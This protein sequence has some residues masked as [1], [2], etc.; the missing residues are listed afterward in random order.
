MVS[1]LTA[2]GRFLWASPSTQ[3]VLGYSPEELTG[4]SA[5]EMIHPA[6]RP[7]AEGLLA[8]T[9]ATPN[10]VGTLSYRVLHRDGSWR[11]LEATGKN[12]LDDPR[13]EGMVLNARDVTD[14]VLAARQ[15]EAARQAAE[16]AN[17]A[18]TA[19]LSRISHELR[20]PLNAI[21]GFAQLLEQD[22]VSEDDRESTSQILRAGHHLMRLIDD[23]LQ[24]SRIE[25]GELQISMEPVR[26]GEV[27]SQALELVRPA[28]AAANVQIHAPAGA[29][30]CIS[31]DVQR[32]RQVLLNLFTNAI[33]Y[34][35]RG[36]HVFIRI[37][38]RPLSRVRVRIADTGRG[39]PRR[40]KPSLFTPFD[41]LGVEST[42]IEGTGLGLA[43]SRRLVEQMNGSIGARS[44]ETRG[45]IFW[46]DLDGAERLPEQPA[47]SGSQHPANHQE[48]PPLSGAILFVDD[49]PSGTRLM[50]RITSSWPDVRLFTATCAGDAI[51]IAAISPPDLLIL[52]LH[53]PDMSGEQLLTRLRSLPHLSRIPVLIVTADVTAIRSTALQRLLPDGFILKPYQLEEMRRSIRSALANSG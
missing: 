3:R 1:V 43:L 30:L 6:D 28:A 32:L 51:Q 2:D 37:S 48:G 31:A 46:V 10:A 8:R 11:E 29:D 42:G 17:G 23:V 5:L 21:L 35:R 41:R 15:L 27:L 49:N 20:T 9:I 13:V 36:G 4:R 45:S 47:A 34:N 7:D 26:L 53:L 39:I 40:R 14:R 12:L 52:D 22:L 50:E 19:F 33:K 38:A 25:Q 44:S 18:K 24:I 16:H